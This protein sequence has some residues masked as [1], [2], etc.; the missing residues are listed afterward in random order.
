MITYRNDLSVTPGGPILNI[1]LSQGDTDFNLIFDLY[2]V[3]GTLT[4]QN[5]STV[6]LEGRHIRDDSTFSINGSISGNAVTIPA[7]SS[8]TSVSGK[9]IAEVVI[10]YN[11]KRL[12]TSN[13]IFIIEPKA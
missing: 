4:I 11:D 5:G 6:K 12:S 7:A 8:L 2:S 13:L 1:S 10:T 9:A 3:A